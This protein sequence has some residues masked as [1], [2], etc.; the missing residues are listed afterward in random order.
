MYLFRPVIFSFLTALAILF[1]PNLADNSFDTT[2]AGKTESINLIADLV[3]IDI[4]LPTATHHNSLGYKLL[5]YTFEPTRVRVSGNVSTI[6]LSS[7]YPFSD[8]IINYSLLI[9]Y[10][11]HTFW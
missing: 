4:V 9:I 11:F 8:S 10:P 5:K 3:A 1:S 2:K 6:N 7:I